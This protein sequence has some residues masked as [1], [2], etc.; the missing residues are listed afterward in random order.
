[1]FFFLH[2]TYNGDYNDTPQ[3]LILKNG[4]VSTT[5]KDQAKIFKWHKF[6]SLDIHRIFIPR[7]M[8]MGEGGGV[9]VHFERAFSFTHLK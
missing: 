5:V 3:P 8:E 2:K 6:G 4:D 7:I 1:M 9:G